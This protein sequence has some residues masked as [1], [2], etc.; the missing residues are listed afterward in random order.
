[1]AGLFGEA[2]IIIRQ[3]T[4]GDPL[5]RSKMW[6]DSGLECGKSASIMEIEDSSPGKTAPHLV[7]F[8]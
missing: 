1:M 8:D 5:I 7:Y 4:N 3:S 6:A 2:G